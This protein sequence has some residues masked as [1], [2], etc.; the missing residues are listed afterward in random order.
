MEPLKYILSGFLLG[1]GI[2]YFMQGFYEPPPQVNYIDQE[3]HDD[4]EIDKVI[5]LEIP[6]EQ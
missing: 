6:Q 5:L 3:M 2:T 1:L 4:Q